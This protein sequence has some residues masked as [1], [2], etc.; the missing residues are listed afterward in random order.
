M[1]VRNEVP[2]KVEITVLPIKKIVEASA[3]SEN[4]S[5]RT[6]MN[7]VFDKIQSLDENT[8]EKNALLLLVKELLDAMPARCAI[9][10][11]AQ[12]NLR[13]KTEELQKYLQYTASSYRRFK[14]LEARTKS[15]DLSDKIEEFQKSIEVFKEESSSPRRDSSPNRQVKSPSAQSVFGLYIGEPSSVEQAPSTPRIS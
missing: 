8:T 6:R 12:R 10:N 4:I 14:G 2:S 7:K 13:S 5:P 3:S 15:H 11:S 1:D 9:V